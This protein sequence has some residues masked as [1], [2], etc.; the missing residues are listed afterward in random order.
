MNNSLGEHFVHK[1][2]KAILTS[3]VTSSQTETAG[4]MAFAEQEMNKLIQLSF[5]FLETPEQ[6][7]T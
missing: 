5:H 1:Y 2:K 3:H 6:N 4:Y 7:S